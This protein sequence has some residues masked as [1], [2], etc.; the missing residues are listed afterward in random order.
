MR[1]VVSIGSNER[2]RENMRLARRRLTELFADIRFSREQQ[3]APIRLHRLCVFSNQV[4]CFH[5]DL[6]LEEVL[7]RLKDIEREAGRTP[8]DKL[9][10]IV[11]LDIDLLMCEDCVLKPEDWERGYVKDGLK[12]LKIQ[13]F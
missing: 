8:E 3:T 2:R 5:S 12:Y 6:R 11:K 13:S 10:E 1:Y 9:R 4:A 7:V